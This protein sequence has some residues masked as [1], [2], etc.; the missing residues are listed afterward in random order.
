MNVKVDLMLKF[1]KPT[2]QITILPIAKLYNFLSPLSLPWASLVTRP[3]IRW[4][5]GAVC[6]LTAAI[7]QTLFF[8]FFSSHSDWMPPAPPLSSNQRIPCI[9]KKSNIICS[10]YRQQV[11]S[12]AP[13][14]RQCL[15]AC[16]TETTEVKSSSPVDKTNGYLHVLWP[17]IFIYFTISV[18]AFY[19][20]FCTTPLHCSFTCRTFTNR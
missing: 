20:A 17:C 4:R 12:A 5:Q 13:G 7:Q 14:T 19:W 11:V 18:S 15:T 9:F 6:A 3:Y 16:S 1:T 2:R 10:G 8:L